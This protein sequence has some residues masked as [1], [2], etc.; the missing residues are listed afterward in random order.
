MIV[1]A[2]EGDPARKGDPE[3]VVVGLA[4]HGSRLDPWPTV[5]W[6]KARPTASS[7]VGLLL[8]SQTISHSL[9]N[10]TKKEEEEWERLS[11]RRKKWERRRN[12]RKKKK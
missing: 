11:A 6:V 1:G 10:D 3:R 4:S 5:S 12:G 2:G 9:L 7:A 8:F